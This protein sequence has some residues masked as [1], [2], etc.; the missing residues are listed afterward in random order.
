MEV[1][2]EC[3]SWPGVVQSGEMVTNPDACIDSG[4][5]GSDLLKTWGVDW[6]VTTVSA[7]RTLRILQRSVSIQSCKGQKARAAQSVED[8]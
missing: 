8:C 5:E 6:A 4:L 3:N 1:I 2:Q 7:K